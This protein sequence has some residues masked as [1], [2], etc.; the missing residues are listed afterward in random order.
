[1]RPCTAQYPQFFVGQSITKCPSKWQLAQCPSRGGGDGVGGEG[2]VTAWTL[3]TR[4][5]DVEGG[6]FEVGR[7]PRV[8][9]GAGLG[10]AVIFGHNA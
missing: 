10:T 1:M 7:V 3:A 8:L 5:C 6:L 4:V 9:L 2:E